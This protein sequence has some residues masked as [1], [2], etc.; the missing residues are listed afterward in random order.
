MHEQLV[1]LTI[2]EA[3]QKYNVAVW[4]IRRWIKAGE[5]PAVFT[6]KRA[7]IADTNMREF[8]LKGNNHPSPEVIPF[9][10]IR[11]VIP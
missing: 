2:K 11:R 1:M 10:K 9:G 4:A 3:A 6:G 7:L 5:L 8:L